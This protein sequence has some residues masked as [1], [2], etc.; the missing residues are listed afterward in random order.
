MSKDLG[1]MLTSINNLLQSKDYYGAFV[2]CL[3]AIE[4]LAA[5]RYPTVPNRRRFQRFLREERQEFLRSEIFL[6]DA[7]KCVGAARKSTPELDDF[8]DDTDAWLAAVDA[9]TQDATRD[10]ITLEEVLWKYCRNP[11]VHEGSRL[12]VDGDT[13]VTLDWSIPESTLSLKVD[14]DAKNLIVIGAP[15]LLSLLYRVVVKNLAP[16]AP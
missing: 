11:I 12:A 5:R 9:F 15:Y 7:K 3:N 4:P 13:S 14:H 8:A 16:K 10:M 1:W 6:P 2:M